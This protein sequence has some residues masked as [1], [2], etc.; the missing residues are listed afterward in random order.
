MYYPL[1][2]PRR[3]QMPGGAGHGQVKAIVC[4]RDRVLFAVLTEKSIWIW[5]SR[6]CVPVVVHQRSEE[7][8]TT[9][10]TNQMLEWRHDSSMIVVSVSDL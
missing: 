6:P 8:V 10:G 9:I 5:F 7:S 4:N 3:L 1:G 2:L